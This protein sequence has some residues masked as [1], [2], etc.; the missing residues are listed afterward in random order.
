MG[1][2]N[3]PDESTLDRYRT[4]ELE[5][6]ERAR[7]EAHLE[8]CAA[9]RARLSGLEAFSGRVGEAYVASRRAAPRPD[10]EAQRA[11]ILDRVDDPVVRPGRWMRLRR[12]APQLAAAAVAVLVIGVLW[13]EG[14]HGPDDAQ[15]AVR[16]PAVER[17][18]RT[19]A[20][21]P[22]AREPAAPVPGDRAPGEEPPAPAAAAGRV[23]GPDGGAPGDVQEEDLEDAPTEEVEQGRA[24]EPEA[25][26]DRRE[27]VAGMRT[28]AAL[29]PPAERFE[30]RARDALA[31]RE[32]SSAR[33]ALAFY[34]DS[35][36]PAA[37]DSVRADTVRALADSLAAWLASSP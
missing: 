20:P 21:E 17:E 2:V 5:S 12:W 25:R 37:L 28:R 36:E 35:V 34:R 27:A 16:S 18:A 23:A 15:R 32:V 8:T 10:W 9:C 30:G 6:E 14:I 4:G 13:Q 19:A 31:K 22:A 11:S 26:P 1:S 3:H 24:A 7:V 29:A 33:E